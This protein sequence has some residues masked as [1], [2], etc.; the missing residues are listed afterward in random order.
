MVE[1]VV[2]LLAIGVHVV[3]IGVLRRL[4]DGEEDALI[5]GR[6]ELGVGVEVEKGER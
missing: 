4:A 5:L 2:E 6:R 3:E 1:Y